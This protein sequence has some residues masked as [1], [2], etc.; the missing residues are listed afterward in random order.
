MMRNTFVVTLFLS[1]FFS[2]VP[3]LASPASANS[4]IANKTNVRVIGDPKGTFRR[5]SSIS[6]TH[7]EVVARNVGTVQ[8]DSV[9]VSLILPSGERVGLSGPA[10]LAPNKSGTYV[11]DPNQQIVSTQKLKAEATCGNCWQK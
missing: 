4:D 11:A 6:L 3:M 2:T 10:T 8:A 1:I 7:V 9:Q 5:S